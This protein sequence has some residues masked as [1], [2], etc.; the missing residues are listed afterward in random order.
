MLDVSDDADD[1]GHLRARRQ[2]DAP[3]R[4]LLEREQP[5]RQRFAHDDARRNGG[6]VARVERSA[7]G[8]RYAHHVEIAG[9]CRAH[10]GLPPHFRRT[11]AHETA[12]PVACQGKLVD[13]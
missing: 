3:A 8:N 12:P 9:A 10:H 1:F 4:R 6:D 2:P 13:D 7:G 5:L 11:Q